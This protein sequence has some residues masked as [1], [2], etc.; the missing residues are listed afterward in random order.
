M[1]N[2]EVF[3]TEFEDVSQ[4]WWKRDENYSIFSNNVVKSY[5]SVLFS[6][7]QIDYVIDL[8]LKILCLMRIS[9]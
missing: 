5:A 6:D 7:C 1:I 8:D 9:V 4:L 3:I 2:I